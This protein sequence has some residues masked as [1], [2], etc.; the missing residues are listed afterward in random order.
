VSF[1]F[2]ALTLG[3]LFLLIASNLATFFF[4]NHALQARNQVKLLQAAETARTKYYADLEAQQVHTQK[5]LHDYK[6]VLASLELSLEP[7]VGMTPPKRGKFLR[8]P[9]T[10]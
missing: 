3:I 1:D 7:S 4:L 6:N 8:R 9:N 5:I 10:H 2:Q